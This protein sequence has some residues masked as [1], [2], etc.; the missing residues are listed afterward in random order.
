MSRLRGMLVAASS[1]SLAAC[2]PPSGAT[3]TVSTGWRT[4]IVSSGRH[5]SFD[6]T[7]GQS[8]TRRLMKIGWFRLRHFGTEATIQPRTGSNTFVEDSLGHG[9]I[10]A[11]IVTSG[12]GDYDKFHLPEMDTVYLYLRWKGPPTPIDSAYF[13]PTTGGNPVGY[14]HV[15]YVENHLPPNVKYSVALARWMFDWNDELAWMTCENGGCCKV[16]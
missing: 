16:R 12:H 10:A 7:H 1:L 6:T 15:E 8:D 4:G 13:V 3:V 5:M 11:R 9:F 14:A 2:A